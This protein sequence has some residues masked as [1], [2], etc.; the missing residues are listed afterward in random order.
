M[1]GDDHVLAVLHHPRMLSSRSGM[2]GLAEALEARKFYYSITWDDIQR[3]SWTLGQWL[4][5]L[6]N[7]YYGS[8]WNALVPW[9]DE[10]RLLR[11]IRREAPRIV[12]FLWAEFAH[13]KRAP[14]Y[15]REGARLVG[16]FHASARKQPDVIRNRAVFEVFDAITLM[17]A[18][19]KPFF[20]ER[21]MREDR[22]H[23]I[24]HG[25]DTDFFKP[26]QDARGKDGEPLRALL[27]GKTERDHDFA[28]AVMKRAPRGVVELTVCTSREHA[29]LYY[30]DVPNVR[31]ASWL[32]DEELRE[33]YQRADLLFM[34]VHDCAANNAVLEAMACGTPVMANRVGGIT[35]YV[36][37]EAG[38]LMDGKK[39]DDWI[40]A[41]RSYVNERTQLRRKGDAA[42][43]Q[44]VALSWR[45]VAISY[46][47]LYER[48]M[49]T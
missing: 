29:K 40:D 38:I 9:L 31:L 24:L 45:K 36:S 49:R 32:S 22:I 26:G 39:T 10:R 14:A 6:G 12:H 8:E 30:Q 20:V 4:R 5:Q 41:L 3:K 28:A 34:P 33:A 21:G 18:S 46:H 47:G 43:S 25:V 42:R 48:L 44:A 16:T 19:Q 13:P 7:R 15:H 37:E 27:V 1:S 11:E 23:V 35:E 17:S 2:D